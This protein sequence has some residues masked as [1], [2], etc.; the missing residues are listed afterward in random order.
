[1]AYGQGHVPGLRGSL[2]TSRKRL[3][4]LLAGGEPDWSAA[5]PQVRRWAAERGLYEPGVNVL[6]AS[7]IGWRERAQRQLAYIEQRLAYYERHHVKKPR[8]GPSPLGT[9][10]LRTV[11]AAWRE[12]LKSI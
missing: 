8:S 7:A 4:A 5:G 11:R 1:M 12:E 3:V 2:H 10:S 9:Q 6:G